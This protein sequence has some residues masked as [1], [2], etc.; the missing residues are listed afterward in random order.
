[1]AAP[2][3]WTRLLYAAHRYVTLLAG[4][5]LLLWSAGGLMFSLL[6][7]DDVHGDFERNFAPP[8]AL[9]MDSVRLSPAEA[10][11]RAASAGVSPERVARLS[12][13]ERRGR[14]VYEFWGEKNRPLG[15]VDASSGEILLR[16][17]EAE[18][19]EAAL[20]DFTPADAVSHATVR[21]VELLEGGP[22][23]EFR[24]GA[25]PAYRVVME[26]PKEPHLYLSAVTGD[27][28]ARRNKPWRVFDFFWMLHIMDYGEREDFNHPL[29]TVMSA[30]AVLTAATGLALWGWRFVRWKRRPSVP[31]LKDAR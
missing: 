21:S 2:T 9:N 4:V 20:A 3:A 16:I 14:A 19:K 5:Q 13:R 15:A 30:F 27:V 18:A 10:S 11:L 26:H 28:L 8:P 17:S 1:M 22:P 25:M 6:D 29:L 31:P 7:I 12:L 24:G 23:L